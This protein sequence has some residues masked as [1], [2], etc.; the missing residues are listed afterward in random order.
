MSLAVTEAIL[1]KQTKLQQNLISTS[2]LISKDCEFPLH[3][4]DLNF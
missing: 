2:I 1:D 4:T 3:L